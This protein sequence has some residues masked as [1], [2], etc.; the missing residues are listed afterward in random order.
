MDDYKE[1]E[2]LVYK[3]ETGYFYIQV[4]DSG[5]DLEYIKTL[6]LYCSI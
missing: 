5:Y 2:P 6:K 4:C 3:L 1:Q